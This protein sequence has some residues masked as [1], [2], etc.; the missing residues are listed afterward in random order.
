MANSLRLIAATLLLLSLHNPALGVVVYSE[1]VGGDLSFRNDAPTD[2]GLFMPGVN[3]VTGQVMIIGDPGA[4]DPSLNPDDAYM[5]MTADVFSFEIPAGAELDSMIMTSFSSGAGSRAF[6]GLA[7]GTEFAYSSY[8]LNFEFPDL[9]LI[10]KG[11]LIGLGDD[12][13]TAFSQGGSG[14]SSPLGPGQ[15]S[16]YIQENMS[17]SDYS[18]SFNVSATSVPESSSVVALERCL[19]WLGCLLPPTSAQAIGGRIGSRYRAIGRFEGPYR[20][21]SAG[22]N[23]RSANSGAADRQDSHHR[24]DA[25]ISGVAEQGG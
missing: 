18:L 12:F 13:L 21:S 7:D 15:Y 2:L 23:T 9:S 16:V 5:D 14:A 4:Y 19:P 8:T 6:I 25:M 17:T 1:A 22:K 20:S 11:A 3:S 24:K 10:R